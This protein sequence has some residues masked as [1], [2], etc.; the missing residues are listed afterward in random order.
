[1]CP[2]RVPDGAV[3]GFIIPIG[4]AEEK[5]NDPL[6]LQRFVELCGGEN[7]DIVVLPTASRL[8]DTGARYERIFRELGAADV[9]AVDFDT[10]RDCAESNRLDRIARASGVFFTGGN[11]LRITTLIGGTP[12]AKL[13]RERNAHGMHVAGTSAGAAVLSEHM[14]AF[15]EEGGSPRAGSVGLSPGLGL[16]NRFIIDQHFRQRDRLGR[17]TT[18]LAFNP[19]AVGIG[20][21]EDTAAFIGPDNTLEV[22]GSGAITVVDASQLQFSSLDRIDDGEPVCLLGLNIH[23]LVRGATFNLHTRRASAGSLNTSKE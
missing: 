6:I 16:T 22:E 4:G 18:A 11:Q 3:R 20:L 10:R 1:M 23:I 14:I 17:L 21:D 15:G 19:F 2:S 8:Q 9:S 7:A 5:Q 13:I 12:V